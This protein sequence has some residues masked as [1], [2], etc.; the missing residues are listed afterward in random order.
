V[1]FLYDELLIADF[2]V[3]ENRL[4]RIEWSLQRG[5]KGTANLQR[6][7]RTLKKVARHLEEGEP[8][9]K[10]VL[11]P[12]EEKTIRGFHFFSGKP[13]AVV[14]NSDESSFGKNP[15]DLERIA[16]SYPVIEFAGKF[17]MELSRLDEED[18]ASLF[19]EDMGISESARTRLTR[20]AYE[21]L[22]R[23]SFYTVGEDEVRA[24]TIHKGDN[25]LEAAGAI[26]SDLARGFIRAECFSTDDLL[27]LGSE[28]K[29]KEMGR[30]RLEGKN[31]IVEPGDILSIR[32]SV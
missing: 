24:W 3:V 25:A 32:F 13:L 14:F 29:I 30:F 1:Q 7:E 18:D 26:H 12:D 15:K 16:E 5:Q 6:E 20:A 19:L 23:I 22:G 28:K 31:Y 21:M 4:E 27:A 2:M 11:P 10:L 17:E 9:W 8:V